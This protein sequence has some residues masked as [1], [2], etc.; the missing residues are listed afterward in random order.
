MGSF[1]ST[2]SYV[3]EYT[4]IYTKYFHRQPPTYLIALT[5]A[6]FLT[7]IIYHVVKVILKWDKGEI[8]PFSEKRQKQAWASY[9]SY[10]EKFV[11]N[12]FQNS[13]QKATFI[14]LHLKDASNKISAPQFIQ[15]DQSGAEKIIT[16]LHA[17]FE[18]KRFKILLLG[19]P[20][21]SKKTTLYSHLRDFI[22]IA[23][24]SDEQPL[25]M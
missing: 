2:I 8:K 9:I 15:R 21:G 1:L 22:V 18:S 25:P 6:I 12:R 14:D 11:N 10:P 23:K 5:V 4:R 17:V 16:S 3:K 19:A 24:G 7:L 20:G 13:M